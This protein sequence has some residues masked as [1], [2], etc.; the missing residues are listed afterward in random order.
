MPVANII[1]RDEILFLLLW[2]SGYIGAKIGIPLS[3]TFTL[4]FY[5]YIIV[6]LIAG[7]VVTW[8]S[9]WRKPD[10]NSA[11][12][13]FFAHFIWLIVIFKSLEYGMNAGSAALIAAVQPILTALIA[14]KLLNEKNNMFEWA[15]IA[16]GFIGV[17][18]FVGGNASFTGTPFWVYLLPLTATVSLTIVTVR[19]RKY[20]GQNQTTEPMPIMTSLFWQGLVTVILLAPLA[21]VFEGYKAQWGLDFVFSVL[22]LGI[23][24]SVLAYAMMF[25]LIRTRDATRVSSLQYFTPATTMLIAW[26]VFGEELSGLGFLGIFITSIGFYLMYKG[27]T[28]SSR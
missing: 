10:M 11:F 2:T 7:L 28:A 13:G 25:Y 5:R 23:I 1:K 16:V 15:G 6:I 8:R 27:K 3:G 17:I 14:P 20:S 19:E 26:V 12:I 9:E 22:W 21:W 4:L 18:V 24:V